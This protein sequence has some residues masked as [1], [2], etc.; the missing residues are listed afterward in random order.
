MCAF[1]VLICTGYHHL[2]LS[3]PYFLLGGGSWLLWALLSVLPVTFALCSQA[4]Y[5]QRSSSKAVPPHGRI[6][7]SLRVFFFSMKLGSPSSFRLRSL[8]VAADREGSQTPSL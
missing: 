2:W 1:P 8:G 3:A 7:C 6:S 4:P 5:L